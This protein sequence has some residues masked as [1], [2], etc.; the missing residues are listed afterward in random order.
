MVFAR[1]LS[2]VDTPSAAEI[3]AFNKEQALNEAALKRKK[4]SEITELKP[5]LRAKILQHI[6]Q[7]KIVLKEANQHNN[8]QFEAFLDC[9][10]R[11][12]DL[13]VRCVVGLHA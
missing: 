5:R 4:E 8:S 6:K 12:L 9:N 1:F 13:Q 3:D 11:S 10:Y 2:I 7:E